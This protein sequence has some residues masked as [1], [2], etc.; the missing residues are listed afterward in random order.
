MHHHLN[1]TTLTLC[2]TIGAAQETSTALTGAQSAPRGTIIGGVVGGVLVLAIVIGSGLW[3]QRRKRNRHSTKGRPT[4]KLPREPQLKY[5]TDDGDVY[6]PE[7]ME[8]YTVERSSSTLPPWA[9]PLGP[10]TTVYQPITNSS[11]RALTSLNPPQQASSSSKFSPY[12][13]SDSLVLGPSSI[14]PQAIENDLSH[15][16]PAYPPAPQSHDSF[17]APLSPRPPTY[18]TIDTP[19][20]QSSQPEFAPLMAQNAVGRTLTDADLEAIAW[21]VSE[22]HRDRRT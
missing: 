16:H 17:S 18:L 2:S 19:H 6:V 1:L 5:H 13:P 21:R 3:Y 14:P 7:F 20:P 10:S 12:L 15:S 9:I 22:V 4:Q 11:E 8:N